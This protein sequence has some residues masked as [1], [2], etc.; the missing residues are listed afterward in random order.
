M[1]VGMDEMRVQEHRTTAP[2]H[3]QYA[4]ERDG[5]RGVPEE[6]AIDWDAGRLEPPRELVGAGLTLVQQQEAHVEAPLAQIRQQRQQVR[7]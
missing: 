4:P 2:H 6:D 5:A 1:E 3:T 7:L